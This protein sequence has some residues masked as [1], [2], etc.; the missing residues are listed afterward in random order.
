MNAIQL[1]R[2]DHKTVRGLLADR[3]STTRRGAKKRASLL[4]L[5]AQ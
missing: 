2:E 4:A 3:E 5:L 1:L